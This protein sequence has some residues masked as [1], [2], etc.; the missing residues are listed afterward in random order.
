MPNWFDKSVPEEPIPSKPL[1]P[2]KL[3][4]DN[5]V[6][7]PL[8]PEQEKAMER[9]SF[10]HK[11]L[12]YLPEVPVQDRKAFVQNQTPKD[13]KL[14]KNLLDLFDKTEFKDLFSS[15]SQ[16]EVPIIGTTKDGKVI[17]GQIDRLVIKSDEVLIVDYKTNRYSPKSKENIPVAYIEQLNAYKD[18]LKN[19]FPDKKIRSFLLWT[20]DSTFTEI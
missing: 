4:E 18:L 12:E 20:T 16:A 2:S 11:L 15:N 19:I 17:C 1:S 3:T 7:S 10:I 5:K 9:G 14:P 6:P 13:I 8:T